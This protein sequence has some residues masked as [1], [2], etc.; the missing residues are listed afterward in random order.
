[1]AKKSKK[2]AILILALIYS[3]QALVYGAGR[4]LELTWNE[5]APLISGRNIELVAP[6]GAYIR[7]EVI[8]V[9]EDGK[10]WSCPG[11]TPSLRVNYP[12]LIF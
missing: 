1:M 6:K 8:A 7:G 3:S 11:V 5:L 4:E 12:D 10:S 2:S 9:R